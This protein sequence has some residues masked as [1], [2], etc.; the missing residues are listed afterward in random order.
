MILS[1]TCLKEDAEH[2]PAAPFSRP[3]V[4]TPVA[5]HPLL[6]LIVAVREYSALVKQTH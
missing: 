2:V 5:A 1:I 6:A 4:L 3:Q